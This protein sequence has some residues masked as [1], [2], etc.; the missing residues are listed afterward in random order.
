MEKLKFHY[1]DGGRREAGFRGTTGDCGARAVAIATGKPYR[2]IYDRINELA[3]A[4]ERTGT[5]KRGISNA[6]TG[7]YR[8]TMDRIMQENGFTW[9]PTMSIGSGC[10]VH[11]RADELPLGTLVVRV[12]KHYACVIDHVLYDTFDCTRDGTRCVYGYWRK[13]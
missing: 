1:H 2:E 10:Q 6:R 5:R 9:V 3:Q 8:N 4:H 13:L 12:S 7:I 11:M